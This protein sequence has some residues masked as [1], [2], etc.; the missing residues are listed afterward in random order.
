MGVLRSRVNSCVYWVLVLIHVVLLSG[1]KSFLN[2]V[3]VLI[4]ASTGFSC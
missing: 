3:L 2:W 4:H 1:V